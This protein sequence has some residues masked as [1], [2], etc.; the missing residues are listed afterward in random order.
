MYCFAHVSWDIPRNRF[1]FGTGS[2]YLLL[3]CEHWLDTVLLLMC[4]VHTVTGI[5]IQVNKY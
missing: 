4:N 3:A 1:F 5:K 2:S